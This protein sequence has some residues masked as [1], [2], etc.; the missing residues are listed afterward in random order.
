MRKIYLEKKDAK[1]FNRLAREQMKHKILADVLFDLQ[2][3]EIEKW[4]KM[5]YLFELE[6]LF[7]EIIS[8]KEHNLI[9]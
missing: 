1:T 4:D 3:C 8:K 6:K 5:E 2:V 9:Y 7:A